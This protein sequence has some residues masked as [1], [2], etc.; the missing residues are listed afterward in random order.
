MKAITREWLVSIGG[1]Y[2]QSDNIEFPLDELSKLIFKVD[3]KMLF[4]S[5]NLGKY[6]LR[7]DW[8]KSGTLDI[9]NVFRFKVMG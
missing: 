3:E 7:F 4:V 6:E 8:T 1:L 5:I 2:T 9:L